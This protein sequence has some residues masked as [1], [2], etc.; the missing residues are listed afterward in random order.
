[1]R[2][3]TSEII[4]LEYRRCDFSPF[5]LDW[6]PELNCKKGQRPWRDLFCAVAHSSPHFQL[7]FANS[8]FVVLRTRGSATGQSPP[9]G[10][11]DIRAWRPM[12]NSCLKEEPTLCVSRTAD[13]ASMFQSKLGQ[14]GI[15]H[16]LHSWVREHA[17][18]DGL[19]QY[20]LGHHL[21]YD[22]GQQGEAGAHYRRAYE[23]APNSPV[24][25]R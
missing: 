6:Y 8:G 16:A 5:D 24:I 12:L 20:L 17:S 21:D 22:L 4:V 10:P 18:R 13:L 15:A 14:P 23:L 2:K 7:L 25:V 3:Y 9:S 11:E 19:A 1:M